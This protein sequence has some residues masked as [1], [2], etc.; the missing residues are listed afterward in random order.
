[1]A[2]QARDHSERILSGAD[3]REASHTPARISAKSAEMI[4]VQVLAEEDDGKHRA[5]KRD[6]MHEHTR[7]VA[8]DKFDAADIEDLRDNARKCRNISDRQERLPCRRDLPV[9]EMFSEEKRQVQD[10][11]D[12]KGDGGETQ[13]MDLRLLA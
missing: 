11:G 5:E 3:C 1:M 12:R 6:Q 9:K 10:R 4:K 2:R 13:P 7:S 8:A